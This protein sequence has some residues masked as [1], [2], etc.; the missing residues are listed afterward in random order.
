MYKQLY[1]KVYSIYIYYTLYMIIYA[2]I[3]KTKN[4]NSNH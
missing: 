4:K 3:N 1:I 2:K